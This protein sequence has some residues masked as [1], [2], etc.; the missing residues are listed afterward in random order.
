[1]DPTN[2]RWQVFW[3]LHHAIAA[4]GHSP[5]VRE[6]AEVVGLATGTV[7]HHLKALK[8]DRLID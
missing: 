8:L 6:L 2:S 3:A 5:T 1:M 4:N 7:H